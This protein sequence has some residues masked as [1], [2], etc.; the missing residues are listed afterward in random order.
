MNVPV[1][2]LVCWLTSASMTAGLTAFS[3]DFFS[4]LEQRKKPY[5]PEHVKEVLD[6]K[7][8]I[9]VK[10]NEGPDYDVVKRVF[11]NDWWKGYEAP[12]PVTG[13]APD[14]VVGPT[15]TPV[16]DLLKILMIQVDT[17]EPE[18]SLIFVRYTGNG[19]EEQDGVLKPD[20]ALPS[21][22]QYAIV[23][24]IRV[25]GVEFRFEDGREVETIEPGSSD[26]ET[27][28]VKVGEDGILYPVREKLPTSSAPPIN[29]TQTTLVGRDRYRVG[30]EDAREINDNYAQILTRDV[31]YRTYHDP[32]TGRR[33]GIKISDV[34]AGSV[35]ERHGVRSG[36][37]IV[38]IN[39][40]P[41]TSEQEAI[42]YVKNNQERFSSWQVVI[43]NM[44]RR[45][46]VTYESPSN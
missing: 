42:K 9:P 23:N 6:E 18:A 27:L 16:A 11:I 37:I 41:V 39:D 33:A 43:E 21:P 15:T 20:D 24:S 32:K 46:T 4:N 28:I 7:I 1:L 8:D 44:G 26:D 17:D 30:T 19:I 25:D 22:H 36:D 29:P 5:D 34:R 12:K 3:Y 40:H 38:S 10:V 35:A 31:T 2:K 13:P 14:E 45:R